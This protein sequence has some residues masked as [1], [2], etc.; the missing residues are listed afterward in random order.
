MHEGSAHKYCIEVLIKCR[1]SGKFRH[2]SEFRIRV[3]TKM[4]SRHA[5]LLANVMSSHNATCANNKLMKSFSDGLK[6][7]KKLRG[8]FRRMRRLSLVSHSNDLSVA[9]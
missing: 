1:L 6:R 5:E 4:G 8:T 2:Y 3:I 9:H 7:V